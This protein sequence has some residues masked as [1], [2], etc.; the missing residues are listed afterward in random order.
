MF[1]ESIKTERRET[2]WRCILTSVPVWVLLIADVG[3]RW[4]IYTVLTDLPKYMKEV[5]HFHIE[6]SGY[7]ASLPFLAMWKVS[8]ISGYVS[9]ILI[10]KG[11]LTI[12]FSRKLFATICEYIDMLF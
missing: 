3:H 12:T 10:S 5:L 4:G 9:D 8:M 11:L 6:Q 2:P 1:S 7:F